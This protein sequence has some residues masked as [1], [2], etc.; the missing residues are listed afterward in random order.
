MKCLSF[1][2]QCACV[3]S[4]FFL[5]GAID[6]SAQY[7]ELLIPPALAGP[8]FD[9]EVQT[10]TREFMS[11]IQTPTYG[12]N[13][14]FLGPTLMMNRGDSVWLRVVNHLG[15][16]TTM[17][18]HGLHLPA[19]CDGGPMQ[20]IKNNDSWTPSFI[21]KNAAATYW[22][23][24]HG[25]GKTELQVS[26]GIAGMIIVR[27]SLEQALA[28]P[29][30]YGIDD[31]PVVIQTKAFDELGQIAIASDMDTMLL[32]NGTQRPVLHAPAQ[33]LR[34]RLLNGSSMRSYY[35]GFSDNRSFSVIGNDDGLLPLPVSRTR[36]L[37]APGERVELLVNCSN[38]QNTSFS[39]RN[40]GTQMTNGIYGSPQ[41]GMGMSSLPDYDKNALNGHDFDVLRIE[42]QEKTTNGLS[43][44][45]TTL[46]ADN[47]P[48][49][50]EVDVQRTLEFSPETMSMQKMV[51]GPFVINGSHFNMDTIN[52]VCRLGDVEIW[53][54]I[55]STLV[56]HPFHIHNQHVYVLDKTSGIV[57][58]AEAGP[59]DV[60]L[61]MPQQ[62]LRFITRFEDYTNAS[63]PYMYHCHMLH[64]EDDGMMGS[65][66]VVEPT[67]GVD[68]EML[69]NPSSDALQVYPM[70]VNTDIH[71]HIPNALIQS[72]QS[73]S[74]VDLHGNTNSTISRDDLAFDASRS[75]VVIHCASQLSDGL[76]C[77]LLRAHDSTV[78]STVF[79]VSHQFNR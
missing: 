11:G 50:G 77:L 16:S 21:V 38:Q 49:L 31:I 2:R 70:P 4:L 15:T 46:V 62:R 53:T 26:K 35:L 42:V 63:V 36:I 10:G 57:D 76:Y 71:C 66:A 67:V 69:V 74:I 13:G 30:E 45:P 51:E 34:L 73:V 7:N 72:L 54:L 48:S 75:S 23:H 8:H 61:V 5:L 55:N 14:A 29:R 43:T 22:Y 17:H 25:E 27:D 59:K 47:R 56:A 44:I 37:I 24:P 64:H 52:Q 9:L 19:V 60:V 18:W 78:Q 79:I 41:V 68:D 3:C 65:F 33:V 58:S 20:L 28:L 40:Y 12:V 6:S 1:F 39:L 32:V